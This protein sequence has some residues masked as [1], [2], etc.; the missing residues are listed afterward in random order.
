MESDKQPSSSSRKVTSDDLAPEKDRA[1]RK[2][3][4]KSI[5]TND[6]SN[7]KR[8]KNK[9]NSSV[10]SVSSTSPISSKKQRK[11][12]KS[13]SKRKSNG[14]DSDEESVDDSQ[15]DYS[16]RMPEVWSCYYDV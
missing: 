8:P 2:P 6:T 9:N 13:A 4:R 10:A 16:E 15:K 5:S 3:T 12:D 14:D 7:T 1:K 11:S